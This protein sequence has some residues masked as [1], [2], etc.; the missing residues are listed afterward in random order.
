MTNKSPSLKLNIIANYASQLYVTGVGILILP[1]YIKYMGAEA[2]GLVGF[3]AM[4]QAWFA[5][6]DLGLTPTIGRETARYHG[7]SMSALMYRQLLRALTAIF[8][9][10]AVIG[11]L[12]LWLFADIIASKWLTVEILSLDVVIFAIQIMAI[13][14]ALRWLCG[15]YRGVVT[16]SEKL[17][18]LSIFNVFIATL[19]FIAVF[20]SMWFYG[21]TPTIFFI[22]QF[23]VAVIELLGLWLMAQLLIPNKK[24]IT[25]PIGWSFKPIKPILKFALTIAF[26]SSVWV[27]VTQTDKLILSGILPLD[28]YGY[29]TLAVLVASGIMVISG[30]VS[31]AIMPRMARLHVEGKHDELIAVYRISTQLV[32]V[33][34]GT[35]AITIAFFAEILLYTWTG[36]KEITESTSPILRL[37]ALGYGVL[38]VAAF[39]YY[40]QYALGNLRYHL[41]GN[42]FM[43]ITLIPMIVFAAIHYGGVGAGYAWLGVNSLYLII[44]V[45]YVHKKLQ[46]GLHLKWLVRD[47]LLI[48]CPVTILLSITLIVPIESTSRWFNLVCLIV[49]SFAAIAT[50]LLSASVFRKKIFYKIK[51]YL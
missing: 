48:Y 49:I 4:L 47:C 24:L 34:A 8:V 38:V 31:S 16:G 33:I 2:Y 10:I 21:Y 36:D 5:M 22:H 42:V 7:G 39:P 15:L 26:T 23:V 6:L 46:P 29:F 37:Y 11:G 44:W 43:V 20:V 1:L 9:S 25:E 51:S 13:S 17:V 27:L 14:V 12:G 3:F 40:L 50:A 41:I 45:G 32:S 19:R 18:W 35:A 30:P 28:E